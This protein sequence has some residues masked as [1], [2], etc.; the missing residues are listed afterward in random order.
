[1]YLLCK[2]FIAFL[3][4]FFS[5]PSVAGAPQEITAFGSNPGQLRMWIYIPDGLRDPAPL[6]VVL[7]GCAQTAAPF[8]EA[9]GWIQYAEQ[10]GVALLLP[11][12]QAANNPGL[13][14]NWF[15][16][17]DTQRDTG[18]ALSI[19]QMIDRVQADYA[20]DR[21]IYGVGLS[22]G[23]AMMAA[24]LASYPDL[25]AGGA[26]IAGIPYGCAKDLKSGLR[27]M[28]TGRDLK[29]KQWA[30]LVQRAH[31]KQAS[32]V[33]CKS[34]VSIW[35]GDADPIV[36]PNNAQELL[37]QWTAVAGIDA[38]PD[39]QESQQGY[40]RQVYQ[41]AQGEN[42]V[43]TYTLSGVGHGAPI[44]LPDDAGKSCGHPTDFVL[45]VGICAPDAIGRFFGLSRTP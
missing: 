19:R 36:N 40:Q 1:M 27:C 34:L 22:A 24:L 38:H 33:R 39:A 11:E 35:Q 13:C 8:A 41:D 9:S 28:E 29:P 15:E 26:I 6:V 14:F 31:R 7:H 32:A 17:D 5:I 42:W 12:Q 43:E 37:E 23:G 18:E 16:P 3:C 21:K 44:A 2:T 25:F 45:P 4:L 10:Q 30:Q 20:I